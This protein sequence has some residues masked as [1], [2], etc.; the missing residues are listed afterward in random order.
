VG[1]H[2]GWYVE[3]AVSNDL[4]PELGMLDKKFY[5]RVNTPAVSSGRTCL[6]L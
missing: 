1:S 3:A 2:M 5:Y 4:N 6:T